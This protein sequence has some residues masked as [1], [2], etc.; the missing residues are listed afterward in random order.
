MSGL[1]SCGTVFALALIAATTLHLSTASA[2][3]VVGTFDIKIYQGYGNGSSTAP[4]EQANLANP[5]FSTSVVADVIYT[6]ALDF[7]ASTNSLGAFFASG[8]GTY[9]GLGA[10]AANLISSGNFAWSTLFSITG[11]AGAATSGTVTH[12]DGA[13]L[14]QGGK[15][16]FDAS[17]PTTAETTAYSVSAGAFQLVYEEVN[18]LPAVLDV[19]YNTVQEPASLGILGLGLTG[20]CFMRRNRRA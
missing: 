16:I 9:T 20:L 3:P 19:E 11:V 13:S 14:Y 1:K 10:A 8:G 6:G 7:N 4:I 2:T 17:A 12:D 18:D 15:T 5:L